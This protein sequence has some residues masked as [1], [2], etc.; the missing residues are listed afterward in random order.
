MPLQADRADMGQ[1]GTVRK[2]HYGTGK[3]PWDTMVEMGIAPEFAAGNVIKNLRRSKDPEHSLESARWYYK[4]L[5]GMIDSNLDNLSKDTSLMRIVAV[6]N[7]LLSE[8]TS[9]ELRLVTAVS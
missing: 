1:D 7:A 6:F 4:Q 2:A 3:Q 8:L 5:R 9:E